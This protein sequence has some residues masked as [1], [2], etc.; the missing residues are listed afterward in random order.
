MIDEYTAA[1][2]RV[3]SLEAAVRELKLGIQVHSHSKSIHAPE[4]VRRYSYYLHKETGPALEEARAHL[5]NLERERAERRR[6]C[7]VA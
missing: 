4:K 1:R 2:R 5:A 7:A 3:R 6:L